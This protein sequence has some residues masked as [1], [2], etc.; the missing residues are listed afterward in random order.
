MGKILVT[1]ATGY[2]GGRLVPELLARGYNV[3]V[4]VR[5]A[6]P[7]HKERWP[8]AEIV[9]AD[10]LDLNSL[11]KALEGV[12]AAF[13]L[14]HSMLFGR[15][16]FVSMDMQAAIN[17]GKAA[18]EKNVRRIIYLGGLGDIHAPLSPHLRS[19]MEV[20]EE[21]KRGK[22]QTTILRAAIIIGSGSASYE[23]IKNLVANVRI[24]LIPYWA[25]TECQPIS[26]RD[27]IKYLV[28]VLEIPETTGKSFDIGGPDILTYEKMLK[29]LSDLLVRKI[30]FMPSPLSWIGLYSYLSNLVTPVPGPI[31]WCLLEGIK[32]KVVCQNNDITRFLPFQP[33]SF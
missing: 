19:R 3:R 24:L 20:A 18:G 29:I 26:I 22:A 16:K 28:G 12:H 7:E 13:Y 21:L 9:V 11:R 33:I 27:V 1:G 8:N 32:Y 2:I 25:R 15:Q 6:F 17:F 23:L 30:L 10:A 14:I 31:I 5:E 4:M